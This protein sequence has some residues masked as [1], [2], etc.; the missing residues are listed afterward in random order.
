[1]LG[2]PGVGIQGNPGPPGVVLYVERPLFNIPGFVRIPV[3]DPGSFIA[4]APSGAQ[5]PQA[6]PTGP[7]GGTT[8]RIEM[9]ISFNR[10]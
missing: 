10:Y 2:P 6:G 8:V 3:S 1:M 9:C 7:P 4:Q 5:Q